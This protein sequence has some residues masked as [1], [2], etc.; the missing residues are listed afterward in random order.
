MEDEQNTHAPAKVLQFRFQYREPVR[1]TLVNSTIGL[2]PSQRDRLNKA[3]EDLKLKGV[4]VNAQRLMR[5]MVDD[6]LTHMG[7]PPDSKV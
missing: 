1:E 7:Y 6:G 5:K 3:V 2:Y 4:K